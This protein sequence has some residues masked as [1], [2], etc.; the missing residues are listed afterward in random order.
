MPHY[1]VCPH[2]AVPNECSCHYRSHRDPSRRKAG[3]GNIF[4]KNL[5][6]SVDNQALHELFGF[7]FVYYVY[8]NIFSKYGT[9]LSLKVQT[10]DN[11]ASKGHGFVQFDTD[12]AAQNAIDNCNG[13]VVSGKPMCI[14]L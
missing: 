8:L 7:F 12:Q 11:G 2:S 6:P 9:I 13:N 5:P 3:V 14:H 1:V 10:D 4:V